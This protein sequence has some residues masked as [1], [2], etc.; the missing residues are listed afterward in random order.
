MPWSAALRL[1]VLSLI[2]AS[3]AVGCSDNNDPSTEDV[4][5]DLVSDAGLDR[6]LDLSPDDG[7]DSDLDLGPDLSSDADLDL[8]SDDGPDDG[9]DQFDST[10]DMPPL[11]CQ[12]NERVQ[13]N[14]CVACA[15]GTV[16]DAGDDMSGVDTQCD[17]PCAVVFGVACG[18]VTS[19]YIKSLNADF[20]D[21]FGYSVALSGD[22][23]V[24]GAATESSS[25]TGVNSASQNS[26]AA[27][28]FVRVNGVW[29]QQ[30]YLKASNTGDDDRFGFSVAISG[31]TLVVGAPDED[32][33]KTDPSDDSVRKSG[34]AYVFARSNGVWT[35]QALLKASNPEPYDQ[36]GYSVGIW[37]DTVV[38]G[39]HEE[40]GDATGVNGAD[41]NDA[42]NSGAAY[43]FA[44]SSG[45]W[46]QQAYLKALNTGE[47]DKFGSSVAIWEDTVV[48]GAITEEGGSSG[49]NGADNN[50]VRNS[51]AA[52][53]FV[54]VNGVW[55]QQ[56]YVKASTP[57]VGDQFGFS[58]AISGDT[59]VVGANTK[60]TP[61]GGGQGI[62]DDTGAAYVFARVNGV[63][64]QQALLTA[65]TVSDYYEIFGH[66][67][68]ISGDTVVVG[69]FAEDGDAT[70]V[71]GSD[72]DNALDSGAA[73]VFARSSGVWSQR[74]YLKA[75]N[76]GGGDLF[77]YS[78]A[79]W[80]DTV[81]V[82]AP[83]E[84]GGATTVN[85]PDNNDKFFSGAAYT[86]EP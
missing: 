14:V 83:L 38:V 16:N 26:G 25:S 35:Q 58:I 13:G 18:A 37:G 19:H 84:E 42:R 76:T 31:D 55:A 46:T 12:V 48:V 70:G 63:W 30:A 64:T 59:F 2:I 68:A 85:G 54:R 81:V 33:T 4:T 61:S 11:L 71:N 66:S 32:S 50:A 47:N 57:A 41:N 7:P 62:I 86:F 77:G 15:A 78:V 67:V 17:D 5:P 28:V 52:Y 22:T 43:V 36:F 9:P 21:L 72:N 44:R 45:V 80:G 23:L 79:A 73:Y 40:D 29:S 49:V 27:Y 56:A 82:G 24:V 6:G 65:S 51:G 1:L 75:S 69:A 3:L 34:A 53:A 8:G 74:A 39:A 10:E 60:D 20:G